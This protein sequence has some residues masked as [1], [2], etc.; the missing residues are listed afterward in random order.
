MARVTGKSLARLHGIAVDQALYRETGNWYH[1]PTNFPSALFDAKGFVYFEDG[2][3]FE[4]FLL[5]TSNSGLR[6]SYETNW[7]TISGGIR[8]CERYIPFERS[9]LTLFGDYYE[10]TQRRVTLNKYERNARARGAC[11]AFHGLNCAVCKMNFEE[12]YGLLG[13]GFIH[14]HHLVPVSS[15][16]SE[17]SLDPINDLRPVC[18]NCHAMLHRRSPPLSV[19]ELVEQA[20]GAHPTTQP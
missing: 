2:A 13:K 9:T 6:F 12:I 19:D 10:G 20:K 4:E 5:D 16:G 18:P 17:Y 3:E 15:I 8:S 7:L 11:I 1:I 14:V